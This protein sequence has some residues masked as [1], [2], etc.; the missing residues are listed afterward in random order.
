MNAILFSREYLTM[1]RDGHMDSKW[2]DEQLLP[3]LPVV[4]QA[5]EAQ[6]IVVAMSLWHAIPAVALLPFYLHAKWSDRVDDP[7]LLA[8]TTLLPCSGTDRRLLE[9]PLCTPSDAY[10]ARVYARWCRSEMGTQLAGDFYLTDWEEGYR[11]H[12]EQVAHHLLGANSYLAVDTVQPIGNCLHGS[13]PS[14]GRLASR[15]A[16][17]PTLLLPGRGVLSDQA[18]VAL[19]SSQLAIVNLQQVRGPRTLETIRG[20]LARRAHL[21]TLMV[22][23]SPSDLFALGLTEVEENVPVHACGGV[24]ALEQLHL[25]LVGQERLQE[26]QKF[27]FAVTELRGY[28][29]ALDAVLDLVERAWW[30]A[31]Q[32]LDTE[33]ARATVLPRLLRAEQYLH[34][35]APVDAGLLTSAH[36]LVEEAIDDEERTQER[37]ERLLESCEHHFNAPAA[38]KTGVVV[39]NEREVE[40]VQQAMS[41]RW[42]A[43]FAELQGLGLEV[44]SVWSA[45]ERYDSLISSGYVGNRTFDIIFASRARQATLLL[46]PV[47]ARVASFHV[48]RMQHLLERAASP[49]TLHVL[50]SIAPAFARVMA[51]TPDTLVHIAIPAFLWNTAT[52]DVPPVELQAP[53][54][55]QREQVL[56]CFTDGTSTIC[57]TCQRFD[58]LDREHGSHLR[59]ASAGDL[60]LGDEVIVIEHD[61]HAVFSIRLMH[62]LDETVLR[63]ECA[64]RLEW[65]AIAASS[66]QV[67]KRSAKSI[68]AGLQ[69]RGVHV[70]Y[71]TVRT[72]VPKPDNVAQGLVPNQ[73]TSFK[74]L[75]DELNLVF[76]EE[77]LHAYH[78]AVRRWRVLHRSA[79]RTLVR[80]MRHAVL[81]QLDAATLHEVEE[82]WGLD[83]RDL[84]RATRIRIVDEV[85]TA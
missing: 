33:S 23:S 39:R 48:A 75:A 43:P 68:Q 73:W 34:T 13:R 83:A 54:T 16:P 69:T 19:S 60:Q 12:R 63:A 74:A 21:A 51:H 27:R 81:G 11:R 10:N 18:L 45:P 3:L 2:I 30:A 61:T 65:L 8:T 40:R 70:D 77:V 25:A 6:G 49:A 1:V 24:P 32:S 42:N 57:D 56:I 80:L 36:M 41:A 37:L 52:E 53:T 55:D 79:G 7:P 14:L 38:W 66:A 72:W 17:R 82:L 59:L 28:S 47:E 58:L 31:R 44:K 85:V 84:L 29:P 78:H 71:A 9:E 22:A 5:L 20:V 62:L 67:Q 46:D 76:P 4:A 64:K 15:G 50:D 26:E 35:V